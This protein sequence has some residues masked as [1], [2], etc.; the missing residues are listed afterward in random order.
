MMLGMSLGAFTTLHVVISLVAIGTGLIVL[1]AL[2]RGAHL[3]G[4]TLTFL[5]TTLLTSVTGFLFP[6]VAITPAV[7]FGIISLVVLLPVFYALYVAKLAGSWRRVYVLGAG[8]ALY[9][10]AFVLIVQSFLKVPFLHPLAP[11]GK[12]PP[13]AIAQLLLLALMVW[14]VLRALRRFRPVATPL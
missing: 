9:L 6:L 7:L 5:L 14:L 11:T 13:F 8:V 4:W 3:Q 12:E 1:V 2:G 10:N